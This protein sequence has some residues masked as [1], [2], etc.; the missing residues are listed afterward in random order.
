[1]D[2][3]SPWQRFRHVTL[4]LLRPVVLFVLVTGIISGFQVFTLVYM[5]TE[6]GPLHST[7]VIVYRIYQ[8]AFEL[9]DVGLKGDQAKIRALLER[10]D[11]T[12]ADYRKLAATHPSCATLYK[13]LAFRSAKKGSL[14]NMIEE[15]RKQ[16]K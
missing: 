7:D 5:M 10:Y 15:Y 16:V 1:M 11:Q 13:A 6:G 9:A 2:G 4:P 3:A 12:W 8:T 14:G